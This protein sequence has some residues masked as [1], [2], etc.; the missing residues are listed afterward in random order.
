MVRANY[1]A[2]LGSEALILTADHGRNIIPCKPLSTVS[3][4]F[5]NGFPIP[6]IEGKGVNS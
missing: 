6:N 1:G 3:T 2:P 4:L 5:Q